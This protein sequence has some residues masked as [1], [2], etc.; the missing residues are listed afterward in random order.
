MTANVAINPDTID[1]LDTLS[2]ALRSAK[3][4]ANILLGLGE[5][6]AVNGTEAAEY[7]GIELERHALRGREALDRLTHRLAL[8]GG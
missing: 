8:V 6:G 1:D 7:L 3:A 5:S 2:A 4:T